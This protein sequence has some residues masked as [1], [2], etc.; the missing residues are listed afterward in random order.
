MA[1]PFT[2]D[3]LPVD[4]WAEY[5]KTQ[6]TR[7]VRIAGGFTVATREGELSCPDGW[8]A[9]DSNGDPYPIAADVFR[10]IYAPA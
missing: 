8:L 2:R 9:L 7:A 1:L 5:R 3:N 4:G 6:T 10:A